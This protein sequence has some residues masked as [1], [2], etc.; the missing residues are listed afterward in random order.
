MSF[1]RGLLKRP[2]N[3]AALVQLELVSLLATESGEQVFRAEAV[4]GLLSAT[5]PSTIPRDA[6]VWSGYRPEWDA[7]RASA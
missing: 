4:A 7:T 5:I 3:F 6:T 2:Y 1:G